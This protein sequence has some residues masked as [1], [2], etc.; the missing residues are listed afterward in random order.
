VG[1]H[2]A[3]RSRN[4]RVRVCAFDRVRPHTNAPSLNRSLPSGPRRGSATSSRARSLAFRISPPCERERGW[5]HLGFRLNQLP[6]QSR[7]WGSLAGF[8]NRTYAASR[9]SPRS[10]RSKYESMLPGG[11]E[12]LER[13]LVNRYFRVGI[14]DRSSCACGPRLW[15]L[16]N[17][18]EQHAPHAGV[19]HP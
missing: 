5:L 2:P 3:C 18:H 7:P 15:P 19:L 9:R 1:D 11:D 10:V 6:S 14:G 12:S 16:R 17:G 13:Q 4:G 8:Y